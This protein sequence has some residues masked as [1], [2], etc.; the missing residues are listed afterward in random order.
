MSVSA[1]PR[2]VG[3][4]RS[5]VSDQRGYTLAAQREQLTETWHPTTGSDPVPPATRFYEDEG[6]SGFTPWEDRPGLRQ[7]MQ[8]AEAG[9]I[10][11]VRIVSMDRLSRSQADHADIVDRLD[12]L[13]VQ[14]HAVDCDPTS[15]FGMP[16][17]RLMAEAAREERRFLAD[18]AAEREVK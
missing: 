17:F 10:D 15:P 3:Y 8:D 12:E 11:V 14:L 13:G 4:V 5:A 2:F 7:L 9:L 16:M 6:L 1:A 18:Q